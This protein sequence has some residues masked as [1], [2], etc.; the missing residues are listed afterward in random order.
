MELFPI[1]WEST[2]LIFG[3]DVQVH[4]PTSKGR[5][6]PWSM[7]LP[8][9]AVPW[10]FDLS[11]FDGYKVKLKVILIYIF[12]MT[13]GIEQLFNCFSA[14]K[15]LLIENPFFSSI[16]H[17]LIGCFSLLICNLWH[18]LYM[19]DI[20]PVRY[21]VGK[22]HFPFSRLLFMSRWWC[23]WPCKSFQFHEISFINF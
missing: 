22:D 21:R 11:H 7:S 20:S 16:P 10:I 17:F 23:P 13:K 5:V 14:I 12:L 4:T 8:A 9:C 1:F 6:F 3:M 15:D 18:S 19:L 2:K